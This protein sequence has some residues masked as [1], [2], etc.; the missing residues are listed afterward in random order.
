MQGDPSWIGT[1]G[2]WKKGKKLVAQNCGIYMNKI[3]NAGVVCNRITELNM[4][5]RKK[6]ANIKSDSSQMK[7]ILC[8]VDYKTVEMIPAK[9][10]LTSYSTYDNQSKY[11]ETKLVPDLQGKMSICVG[12]K[13]GSAT[14]NINIDEYDLEK[15]YSTWKKNFHKSALHNKSNLEND[16]FLTV[17]ESAERSDKNPNVQN[18][19]PPYA[20]PDGPFE[21][22]KLNIPKQA[23]DHLDRTLTPLPNADKDPTFKKKSCTAY[24]DSFSLLRPY[25]DVQPEEV[26]GV[27]RTNFPWIHSNGMK[28]IL[29][30]NY[31]SGDDHAYGLFPCAEEVHGSAV[32]VHD[33]AEEVY[34]SAEEVHDSAEEVH[35]SAVE[36]HGSAEEVHGSTDAPRHFVA[37]QNG[38]SDTYCVHANYSRGRSEEHLEHPL[39]QVDANNQ[40]KRC[41]IHSSYKTDE[42]GKNLPNFH[43]PQRGKALR[44]EGSPSEGA[45]LKEQYDHREDLKNYEHGHAENSGYFGYGKNCQCAHNKVVPLSHFGTPDV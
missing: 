16:R 10:P 5:S 1:Q 37:S 8:H 42:F 33:S 18:R 12:R 31:P 28:Q 4:N 29:T 17:N 30:Y 38:D 23:R 20:N 21:K 11:F 24:Q 41:D 25:G 13:S 44:R 9:R 35:D 39:N 34:G 7:D 45:E 32:Q 2:E 15:T 27:K 19:N 14:V 43:Q 26:K 3:K 6:I 36:E 40:S 22:E